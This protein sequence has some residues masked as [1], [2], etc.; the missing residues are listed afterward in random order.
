MLLSLTEGWGVKSKMLEQPYIPQYAFQK[1]RLCLAKTRKSTPCQAPA[2]NGKPRCR[3]HGGAKGSG[4]PKGNSNAYKHGRFTK[5]ALELNAAIR[6]LAKQVDNIFLLDPDAIEGG[7]LNKL[8]DNQDELER[9][10]DE[11]LR[12]L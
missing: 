2:T 7:D 3:L 6:V 8:P 11:V 1:A 10:I 5:K 12:Y 4:A 9:K